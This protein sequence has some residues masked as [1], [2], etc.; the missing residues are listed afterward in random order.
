MAVSNRGLVGPVLTLFTRL[1]AACIDP[2]LSKCKPVFKDGAFILPQVVTAVPLK[3]SQLVSTDGGSDSEL[4]Y[5]DHPV[6][7]YFNF[8]RN[9]V[10]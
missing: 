2:G 10:G 3:L 4:C 5:R 1:L 7:I 6:R 8:T 9:L